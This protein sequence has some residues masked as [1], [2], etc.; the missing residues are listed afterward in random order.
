VPTIGEGWVTSVVIDG[1]IADIVGTSI[2][3]API[4]VPQL[5]LRELHQ[6]ADSGDKLRR[7]RGRLG[8]ETLNR[9]R[10][11]PGVDVRVQDLGIDGDDRPVDE[12]LVRIAKALHGRLM[13]MDYNLNRLAGV[14][15]IRVVNLNE[16]SNAVKPIVVPDEHLSVKLVKRGEQPGQAVGY[17]PDGTMVIV[18]E[19]AHLIGREATV[20][21]RNSITRPT[22]RMIFAQIPKEPPA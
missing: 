19:A 20:V 1:R 3:D 18:E 22:G 12:Q 7:E 4:V 13:T 11:A 15:G 6:I 10:A 14:E 5:V 17:L 9:L 8:L 16:L 21:V 2:I